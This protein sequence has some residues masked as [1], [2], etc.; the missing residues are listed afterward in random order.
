MTKPK[1]SE[2]WLVRFPFSDLSSTKL[3]PALVIAIEQ[4]LTLV[5]G[6]LSNYQRIQALGYNLKLDNW[7][8]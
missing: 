8:T 1:P 5:S 6:K 7:R 4:N 2:I 3:R